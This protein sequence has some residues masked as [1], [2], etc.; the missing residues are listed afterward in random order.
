MDQEKIPAIQVEDLNIGYGDRTVLRDLHFTVNRGDI[1]VIMGP[2]G[3]GK[4]TL[5]KSMIGLNQPWAGRVL[6][7]RENFWEKDEQARQFLMRKFGVLYQSGALWSSLTLEENVALPLQLYTDLPAEKIQSEVVLRLSLVGL[8]GYE[9]FYPSEISGGMRKRAGL[10]RAIALNPE[11]I[12]FDEPSAGL[13]PV[14][15]QHLDELILQLRDAMGATIVIVT[16]ELASIFAVG[17]NSIYLDPE[18]KTIIAT[19]RPLDLLST[20]KDPKVI[21]FLTRGK[22]QGVP[23]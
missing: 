22:K 11:I 17:S 1:F 6:F 12:F 21:E 5:L 13:D 9:D 18:S 14:S 19:G 2:S 3:C 23:S 7:G 15:A 10:A 4:S 20:S 16:H 8:E